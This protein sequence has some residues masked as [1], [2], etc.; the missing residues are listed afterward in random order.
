[1]K[2][3]LVP[4]IFL[5]VFWGLVILHP[6]CTKKDQSPV[7]SFTVFPTSGTPATQFSL[8]ASGSQDE[9]TEA[10]KLLIR[11]DWDNDGVWEDDW[12]LDKNRSHQYE[13]EG[14]YLIRMEVKDENGGINSATGALKVTNSD[15]L[16]P[17]HTPF[18]YNAGIN[19]ETWTLGRNKRNIARDLDTIS[20]HFRLVKTF[21]CEAVGTSQV[22]MDPTQQEVIDYVL[23]HQDKS[24]ELALGTSDAVLAIKG[25]GSQWSAGLMTTKTY[26]DKWV[27]MLI[28]GFQT[29]ANVKK[30]VRMIL[31]GNEIDANG[32]PISTTYFKTYYTQWIPQAFQNLKKS[33]AEAGLNEI[34]VSTIIANY[35]LGD[36]GSNVVA[37]SATAYIKANWSSSWNQGTPFVLFN[38]YTQNKGKSVDFGPVINYFESVH[39]KLAGSPN[40]Y[41]GETGFSAEYTVEN[42]AKV[43]KQVFAWLESQHKTGGLTVPLFVFQAYDCPDKPEGQKKMGIFSDDSQNKPLGL[44]KGINVPQWIIHPKN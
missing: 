15:Q 9:E 30:H 37:S 21:H 11:L 27:K 32:P 19:Y 16:I 44:K 6:A 35:P 5:S 12:S 3:Q 39:S 42:E 31:L 25:S 33:L 23:A 8:D 10:S 29:P 40:V 43:L 34:P 7:A 14:D 38:Q 28:T 36:P 20:R 24:V 13:E 22:I 41:I 26:T 4:L 1:M 17:A 2:K 18:S